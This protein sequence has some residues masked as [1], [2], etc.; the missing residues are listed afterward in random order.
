MDEFEIRKMLSE[1][2]REAQR[3]NELF[4]QKVLEL[5]ARRFTEASRS[6]VEHED[7]FSDCAYG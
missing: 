1:W 7:D 3:D 5:I 4:Q 2:R 6:L